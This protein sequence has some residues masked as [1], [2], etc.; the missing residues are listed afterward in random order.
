MSHGSFGRIGSSHLEQ[1]KTRFC[2]RVLGQYRPFLYPE[3]RVSRYST[4]AVTPA[5]AFRMNVQ[6]FVLL[7]PLEQAPDQTTSRPFVALSVI[8]VPVAK[9]AE[10]VLPTATS[11][12]T[13][14]EVIRSPLRPVAVTV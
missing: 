3:R 12:P 8:E 14:F 11:M 9:E 2:R 10:L 13:G 5:L 6:D 7:P 4:F 1:R